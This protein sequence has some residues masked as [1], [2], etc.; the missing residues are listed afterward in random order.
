MMIYQQRAMEEEQYNWLVYFSY[1]MYMELF[2]KKKRKKNMVHLLAAII[3][4]A[5]F[6]FPI[7][8]SNFWG[9]CCIPFHHGTW[10]HILYKK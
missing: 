2:E 1:I 3:A 4:Y 7:S 8:Q 5:Y 9:G 6:E 10:L